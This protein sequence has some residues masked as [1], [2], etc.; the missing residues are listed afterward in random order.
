MTQARKTNTESRNSALSSRACTWSSCGETGSCCERQKSKPVELASGAGSEGNGGTDAENGRTGGRSGAAR[1]TN[2]RASTPDSS[3][4]YTNAA[5]TSDP[6]VN[7]RSTTR[8]CPQRA[9]GVR[10][11]TA[12]P[13]MSMWPPQSFIMSL[14]SARCLT[15]EISLKLRDH[16]CWKSFSSTAE[17]F[18]CVTPRTRL[19]PTSLMGVTAKEASA[20]SSTNGARKLGIRIEWT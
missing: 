8:P 20:K 16:C 18:H 17:M 4:E 15:L 19:H 14:G 3:L 6:K 1:E 7:V 9:L 13:R 5:S 12:R 10:S 11:V 2:S